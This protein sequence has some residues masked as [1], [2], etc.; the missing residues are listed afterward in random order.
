MRCQRS[1]FR[2]R[3]GPNGTTSVSRTFAVATSAS[4]GTTPS[5]AKPLDDLGPNVRGE[6]PVF[7]NKQ[8]LVHSAIA[9]KN[10]I[11]HLPHRPRLHLR[12]ERADGRRRPPPARDPSPAA[13]ASHDA[14][15][16][17]VLD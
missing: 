4:A 5:Q 3:L 17:R 9:E 1:P 16:K 15:R 7:R 6:R 14:S 8:Q 2:I 12:T 10:A 13:A 11:A